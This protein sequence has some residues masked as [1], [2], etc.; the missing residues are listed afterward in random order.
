MSLSVSIIAKDKGFD[1]KDLESQIPYPHNSLFGF[2]SWRRLLW[3]HEVIQS[4]SC[5]LIHSLKD[6]NVSVFDEDVSRLRAEFE[7]IRDN[8]D[9]IA[10]STGID[11]TSIEFRVGN[12]LEAISVAEKNLDKVGIALW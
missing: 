2:E 8:V 7:K 4:L 1:T 5:E 11:V 12:A 9:V 6:G 10:T 3:G